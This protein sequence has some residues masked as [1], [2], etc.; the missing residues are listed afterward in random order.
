MGD[1]QDGPV[2]RR[3]EHVRD[4]RFRRGDVEMRRRL[5]ED[6]HRSVGEERPRD[7]EARAASPARDR[8]ITS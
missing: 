7:D 1:E 8:T 5:V 3:S 6:Q 2:V 4:E